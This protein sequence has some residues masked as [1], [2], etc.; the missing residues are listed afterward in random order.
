MGPVL[1]GRL[2]P[3]ARCHLGHRG[4]HLRDQRP[5]S[6]HGLSVAAELRLAVHRRQCQGRDE[7]G[8]RRRLLQRS[9]FWSD[10][11]PAHHAAA[12]RSYVPGRRP[13]RHR[14]RPRRR[15]TDRSRRRDAVMKSMGA[16]QEEY[17]RGVRMV[18]YD[19]VKELVLALAGVGI[20]ALAVSAILSSPDVPPVTVAAWAQ[21]DP[22]DFATTAT[23]ELAGSTTSTRY[24]NP[25]NTP[26]LLFMG[27][28]SYLSG[29][30]EQS[31]L[32]GDQWGMMNETGRY[33]GQTWLW[34]YTMWYQVPPFTSDTG[35]LG[36]NASN[37]DLGIIILMTLLTAALA[38]VPLIPILRDI[39]RWVPIHR[40]I[41][42]GYYSP[43]ARP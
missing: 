34:L 17:Y 43:K 41:W 8:R 1:H 3:R 28:G 15:Q 38:L 27:D 16:T 36:I 13:H 35:F 2:A 14:P 21:N 18:P 31:N 24:G 10:V 26:A 12:D 22:V 23:G 39:P 6:V 11:R 32:L 4:R 33:P 20:L 30:A 7:W 40:L 5:D 9:E 19:L 42:R 29:L 37:A 25:Y